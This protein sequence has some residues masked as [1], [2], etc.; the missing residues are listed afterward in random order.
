MYAPTTQLETAAPAIPAA[1]GNIHF[2]IRRN[3]CTCPVDD[4]VSECNLLALPVT[5]TSVADDVEPSDSLLETVPATNLI[6]LHYLGSKYQRRTFTAF[7]VSRR[8]QRYTPAVRK[9]F[10]L[11]CFAL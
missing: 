6:N 2:P 4:E 5:R 3:A 7:S 9:T 10:A 8:G 11:S 1:A